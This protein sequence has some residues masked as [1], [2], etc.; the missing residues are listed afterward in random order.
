VTKAIKSDPIKKYYLALCKFPKHERFIVK[1]SRN[2]FVLS[3]SFGVALFCMQ[4]VFVNAQ[5]PYPSKPIRIIVPF[6]PG[7]AN[8]FLARLLAERM[9]QNI[10]QPIIVENKVGA[11][12]NIATEYVARQ[13]ADGYTLLV[14]ANTH[15]TNPS[16]F[17]KL[18]FDP[19][20]DFEPVTLAVTIPFVLVVSSAI[21]ANNVRE[22]IALARAKP[23]TITFGTAGIGT[24]HHLAAEL[25]KSMATIDMVHVPYKGGGPII[26]ALITGEVNSAIAAINSLIPLIKA[27][28][29]RAL[30]LAGPERL[31]ILPDVPTIAE[32]GPV[33]GYDVDSWLAI[34]APV[35]TPKHIVSRLNTEI[36]R[37]VRDPQVKADKL[38]PVGLKGAGT[39]PER[40]GEIMRADLAKWAKVVKD[41]NIP[42]NE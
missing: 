17:A 3:V 37:I 12:G 14:S 26:P 35:G 22:F 30:G 24:P 23:G 20:K 6:P 29:I 5:A 7:G 32:N 33:P 28:K 16:F 2:L 27:G 10:G 18:P 39:T 21:P 1:I 38:A 13:P 40:L 25:L 19:I 9:F 36:N 4:A 41:A 42:R 31:T 15:I 11:A 8:D 34:L